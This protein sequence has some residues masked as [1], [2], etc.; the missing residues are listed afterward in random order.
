MLDR[1]LWL[2]RAL[3]LHSDPVFSTRISLLS[4]P[5]IRSKCLLAVHGAAKFAELKP[6]AFDKFRFGVALFG[7]KANNIHG[8]DSELAFDLRGLRARGLRET[9]TGFVLCGDLDE[10]ESIHSPS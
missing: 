6:H 1:L 7:Q 3:E 4:R 10:C 9:E 2:S 5:R 8:I